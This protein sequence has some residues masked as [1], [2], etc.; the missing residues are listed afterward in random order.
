MNN[1]TRAIPGLRRLRRA[2][3]SLDRFYVDRVQV[4]N[5]PLGSHFATAAAPAIVAGLA[6][7]LIRATSGD[8]PAPDPTTGADLNRALVTSEAILASVGV[9]FALALVSA[10]AT[11]QS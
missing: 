5:N 10:V 7:T 4:Q 3:R 6:I 1:R 11:R 9:G 8:S 2:R